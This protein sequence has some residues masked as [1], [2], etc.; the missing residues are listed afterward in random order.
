MRSL[1]TYKARSEN[2]LQK[3]PE[4]SPGVQSAMRFRM[5]FGSHFV[6][7]VGPHAVRRNQDFIQTF[8]WKII[9]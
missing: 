4:C 3:P 6:F 5:S 8:R 9:S 2:K 1:Y 7:G